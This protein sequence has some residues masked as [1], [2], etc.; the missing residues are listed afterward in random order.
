M[1]YAETKE[2]ADRLGLRF[3][4]AQN[5]VLADDYAFLHHLARGE[6]RYACNVLSGPYRQSEILAFDYHYE[7]SEKGA[8]NELSR[9]HYYSTA[10]MVLMPAYFP[11]LLIAPQG[12]LSKT[13]ELFGGGDINFESAEFSRAFSVRSRDKRFAYDVC[14]GQVIDYLLANRDLD[15]QIQNCVLALVSDTQWLAK[16]VEDNLE[17]LGEIRAR[18]PEYLFQ[19]T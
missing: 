2:L 11:E 6:N 12:L 10:V 3:D 19:K 14:N 8:D 15:L 16:Q 1:D 9:T 5:Y 17:R 7:I 18:L 4:P 13:T